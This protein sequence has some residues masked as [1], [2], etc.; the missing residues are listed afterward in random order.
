M[1]CTLTEV[2]SLEELPAETVEEAMRV[3]DVDGDCYLDFKEFVAWYNQRAFSSY[4]SLSKEGRECRDV[5]H[6]LGMPV[7][8]ADHCKY[9]FDKFDRDQNK[10]L[11]FNEFREFLNSLLGSRF[12]SR[13]KV[14]LPESRIVHFWQLCDLKGAG[15]VTFDE[16][17]VFYSQHFEPD[18]FDP[19]ESFYGCIRGQGAKMVEEEKELSK[20]RDEERSKKKERRKE[21]A[22]R[23]LG[24][25]DS[26]Q[27]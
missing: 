12:D 21:L 17:A 24:G 20:L 5:A 6:R 13:K 16:F 2:S 22:S 10:Y 23:A 26:S 14:D 4:V 11:D 1:L 27:E 3:G 18:S 15:H 25:E 7:S 8:D 9:L 19:G